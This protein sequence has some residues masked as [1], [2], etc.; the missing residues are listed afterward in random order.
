MVM[1]ASGRDIVELFGFTPDDT[2]AK[3][4]S[5]WREKSC[6]FT[7]GLCTKTNHD[8]SSVY[9]TCSVTSGVNQAEGS[10]IIVCPKRLYAEQHKIFNH[11]LE[12]AWPKKGKT[13]L[14]CGSLSDLKKRALAASNPVVA[15]GQNSGKEFQVNSNGT[16]SMDWV[17]QAYAT[18]KDKLL[19]QE[20][21][22][23]EIQSIDI[24]GNYRDT[25]DAYKKIKEGRSVNN[26]PDS[27]HGL[28]WANVHKRLIPQIIRKG[29]IYAKIERCI[30]FY[31]IVPDT[32]YKKFEE[33]IGN[34]PII[35]R[36]G[37][38]N[39]SVITFKLGKKVPQGQ[40]RKLELVRQ[41]HYPLEAVANAFI[42]NVSE[43]APDQLD[44]SLRD[45]LA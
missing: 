7:S 16:L 25:W 33:V 5:V 38:E 15:F 20:F 19:P 40:S 37:R 18:D 28:N 13:L 2:S 39:L 3:A 45:I 26:V 21:V 8:Q 34:V 29:N 24:T 17:L 42:R 1:R 11:I 44:K 9:G 6:P 41:V 22:G 43:D 12:S 10:E 27:G 35:D 31:F 30:G 23:L 36:P 32:V 4:L 14:S